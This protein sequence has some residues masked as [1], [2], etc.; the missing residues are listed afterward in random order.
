MKK[1]KIL[2]LTTLGVFT[3]II[4]LMAFTPL[5]YLKIGVVELTL[6]QIPVAIGA[7][8]L[9]PVGGAI[10]GAVFGFTSFYQCFSGALGELLL[11]INPFLTAVMCIVPRIL[12]GAGCGLVFRLTSK[13]R[14]KHFTT[15]VAIFASA[16]MALAYT[17]IVSSNV[18]SAAEAGKEVKWVIFYI[19]SLFV[20]V[21]IGF[22][23]HMIAK[24]E[25][26]TAPAVLASFSAAAL[27][28]VFFVG[29]LVLFFG[30]NAKVLELFGTNGVMGIIL[31][32]VTLNA[33]VELAASIVLGSAVSKA[34]LVVGK[35]YF[36]VGKTEKSSEQP[37]TE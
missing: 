36:S 27:N 6:L 20:G 35:R 25:R 13:I 26:D 14:A 10:L 21:L 7:I 12:M 8:L 1:N 37:K 17:V 24:M 28:T 9:G 2:Y 23:Y 5:G 22:A 18:N 29:A 30:R 4:L 32:L 16:V 31:G 33:V 34:V 19:A 15:G 11:Q 3:A